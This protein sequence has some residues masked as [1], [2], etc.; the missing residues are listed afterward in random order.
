M[1]HPE[2]RRATPPPKPDSRSDTASVGNVGTG[3]HL[4]MRLHG[5]LVWAICF[6]SLAFRS[7][8]LH[9]LVTMDHVIMC[10]LQVHWGIGFARVLSKVDVESPAHHLPRG[11]SVGSRRNRCSCSTPARHLS[12]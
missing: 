2:V 7:V 8:G 4:S 3:D 9:L 10:A 11:E 6:F 1:L 5:L 12:S